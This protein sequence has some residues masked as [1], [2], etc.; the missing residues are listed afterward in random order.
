VIFIKVAIEHNSIVPS[1]F[2]APITQALPINGKK[3]AIKF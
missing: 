1:S 3:K 2:S